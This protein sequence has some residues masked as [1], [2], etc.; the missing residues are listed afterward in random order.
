MKDQVSHSFGGHTLLG[1]AHGPVH[2]QDQR[3]PGHKGGSP[4]AEAVRCDH[5]CTAPKTRI[6]RICGTDAYLPCHP[7]TQVALDHG[8]EALHTLA[9]D[10]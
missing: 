7:G 5:N 4:K 3:V 1:V 2:Q 8:G 6:L 9:F 10:R